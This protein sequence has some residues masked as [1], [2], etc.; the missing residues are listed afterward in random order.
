MGKLNLEDLIH[1]PALTPSFSTYNIAVD[2][3]LDFEIKIVMMGEMVILKNEERDSRVVVVPGINKIEEREEAGPST[4]TRDVKG[5]L[6]EEEEQQPFRGMG[7]EAE[8]LEERR[9]EE[10]R[11]EQQRQQQGYTKPPAGEGDEQLPAY[12]P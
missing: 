1:T 8:V 10:Q 2:Y 11:R 3:S 5:V 7:K 9:E 12:E 4:T 6:A